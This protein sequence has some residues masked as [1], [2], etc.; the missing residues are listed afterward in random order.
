MEKLTKEALIKY[1]RDRKYVFLFAAVVMALT[2]VPYLIGYGSQDEAWKYTGFVIGVEDGN[3]YIAKMLSGATGE[4]IFRT[5]YSAGHQKGVLA[6][7]PYL[8]IGKLSAQPAQHEQLVALFH[9]FRI[10]S[11]VL[12]ILAGFDFI[13]LFINEKKW[14]WWALAVYT[15]G[16]GGGWVLV[17]LEQKNFFGSL[18]L[19][20][21]SPESFGFLGLLGFPHL[22]LARALFLWGLTVYLRELPGYLIGFLW[23][24]MGFFQPMYVVIAWVVVA[25]HFLLISASI[26]IKEKG[27]KKKIWKEVGGFGLNA[28]QAT[29]ISS[30]LVVYT[31]I[32]FMTDPF[33]KIWTEQN[34]LPSPHFFHYLVAY[35]IFIPFVLLGLKNLLKNEYKKSRLLAGWLL[36]LPLLI[37]APVPTQRRLAEGIWA[38]ISIAMISYFENRIRMKYIEKWILYLAFPSTILLMFGSIISVKNPGTPLFRPSLE[39][40]AFKYLSENASPG[41]V[42]LSSFETGNNLPAWAPHRVVLGHGPETMNREEVEIEIKQFYTP[43]ATDEYRQLIL[44]KYGVDYVFLGPLEKDLGYWDPGSTDYLEE[45]F[46]NEDYAIYKNIPLP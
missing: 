7:F 6:F 20:F 4:W 21:I 10:L 44:T 22:V 8:L 32:E 33:L 18:P 29:I 5:P 39:I 43:V 28:L 1:C 3:S 35:G 2:T 36:L 45:Y 9:W 15:L 19:E 17:I 41:S 40:D 31:A 34:I 42:V 25:V 13:S 37:T 26:T 27:N 46:S 16:G 38:V 12:A 24:I 23:L 11:G 14:Q 30:P